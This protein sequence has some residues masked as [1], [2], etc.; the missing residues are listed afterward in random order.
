MINLTPGFLLFFQSDFEKRL[1]EV[2]TNENQVDTNEQCS[3]VENE[4]VQVRVNV[5]FDKSM[6]GV[7]YTSE[8]S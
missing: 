6:L 2:H 7:Q 3:L 8:L 1:Q 4:G 5:I